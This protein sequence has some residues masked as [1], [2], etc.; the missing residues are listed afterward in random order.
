MILC[1]W[2]V[3]AEPKLSA[4]I[5]TMNNKF[6]F[7]E[8]FE[9]LLTRAEYSPMSAPMRNQIVTGTVVSF[10][11]MGFLVSFNENYKSDGFVPIK[12][13]GDITIGSVFKFKV[14]S[15]PDEFDLV[16]LSRLEPQQFD[17][18]NKLVISGQTV[19]A[20]VIRV[21][22]NK[23]GFENGL[24]ATIEGIV[25]FIPKSLIG[26][27]CNLETLIGKEMPVKV[28]DIDQS[29]RHLRLLLNNKEA[30]RETEAKFLSTLCQGQVLEV[31]VRKFIDCGVLVD[32]VDTERVS[33]LIHRTEVSSH[34]GIHPTDILEEGEIVNAEV[35]Q[36]DMKRHRCSLSIRRLEDRLRQEAQQQ[37]LAELRPGVEVDAR[38]STIEVYGAIVHLGS[39]VN[40]LLHCT[41]FRIVPACEGKGVGP[42]ELLK[43]QV[44]RVRIK[45]NDAESGRVSV[46]RQF[47]ESK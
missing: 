43:G 7:E 18:F 33:G 35:V 25:G 15:N 38:I 44:I 9:Q 11:K 34:P 14:V 46:T 10:G 23:S 28:E 47:E 12:L 6:D 24:L 13:A 17:R 45:I 26:T 39:D 30:V 1:F 32:F 19:N 41:D 16:L 20:L 3:S 5:K 27:P 2:T 4:A 29:R 8:S 31:R 21:Q 40:G 22:R 42:E 36:I 37:R